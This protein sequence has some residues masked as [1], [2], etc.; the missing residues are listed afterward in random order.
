MSTSI[1]QYTR[2]IRGTATV[3]SMQPNNIKIPRLNIEIIPTNTLPKFP[4]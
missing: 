3:K 1:T 2:N 4:R